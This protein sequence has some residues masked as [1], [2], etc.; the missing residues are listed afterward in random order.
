MRLKLILAVLLILFLIG[1]SGEPEVVVGPS[2][3]TVVDDAV[4]DTNDTTTDDTTTD[5]TTNDTTTDD[6]TTDTNFTGIDGDYLIE[7]KEYSLVPKIQT[8][9]VG[10]TVT[11]KNVKPEGQRNSKAQI[12]RVRGV[13]PASIKSPYFYPGET[14]SYTFEE[15]GECHYREILQGDYAGKIIIE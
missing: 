12:W 1:C 3:D 15:A 4:T 6:T 11:W 13:C 9:M 7:V 8:I 14:Y 10:E 2:N 5:T